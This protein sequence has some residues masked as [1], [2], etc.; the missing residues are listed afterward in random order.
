MKA[1]RDAV[2]WKH[3][4]PGHRVAAFMLS[5]GRSNCL[6]PDFIGGKTK[7]CASRSYRR[8]PAGARSLGHCLNRAQKERAHQLG[9]SRTLIDHAGQRI[10]KRHGLGCKAGKQALAQKLG[11]QLPSTTISAEFHQRLLD[12]QS[13]QQIADAMGLTLIAVR[14]RTKKIFKQ[15]GVKGRNGLFEKYAKITTF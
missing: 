8:T 13:N 5:P 9:V 11:L 3:W 12:G 7:L 14:S 2:V 6:R 15:E 10:H 4:V 1:A